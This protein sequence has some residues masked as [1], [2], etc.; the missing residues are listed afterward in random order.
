MNKGP[1]S[2]QA[3]AFPCCFLNVK[4]VAKCTQDEPQEPRLNLSAERGEE[5]PL[6][7]HWV[8][9]SV[10]VAARGQGL[11]CVAHQGGTS[12]LLS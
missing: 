4:G 11:G 5:W 7:Q 2:S 3:Q 8:C 12:L 9:L 10:G 6:V 1:A